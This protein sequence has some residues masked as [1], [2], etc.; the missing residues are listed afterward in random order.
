MTCTR[1]A[2]ILLRHIATRPDTRPRGLFR[3]H[4]LFCCGFLTCRRRDH[5]SQP[6]VPSVRAVFRREFLVALQVN[7]ALVGKAEAPE[8]LPRS[9]RIANTLS[10]RLIDSPLRN[11]QNRSAS[12][13]V[14]LCS[15]Q[16]VHERP[17]ARMAN[18][19]FSSDPPPAQATQPAMPSLLRSGSPR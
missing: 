14:P 4:S 13:S 17:V 18:V 2:E 12:Q 8:A 19:S 3:D 10:N 15:A 9:R 6:Y 16:I 11:L 7:I 5:E 1:N